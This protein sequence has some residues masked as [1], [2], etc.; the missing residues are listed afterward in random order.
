MSLTGTDAERACTV[1][2]MNGG[3]SVN[4][5]NSYTYRSSLTPVITSVTPRRGGTAGGTRL[6][7]TGSGFRCRTDQNCIILKLIVLQPCFNTQC[8]LNVALLLQSK[9]FHCIAQSTP[10]LLHY[11]SIDYILL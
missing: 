6:M 10:A 1:I 5:T 2:V 8:S 9:T 7:I 4:L 3:D 11:F